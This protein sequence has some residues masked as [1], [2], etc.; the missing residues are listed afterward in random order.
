[1]TVG[2][3]NARL[4]LGEHVGRVVGEQFGLGVDDQFGEQGGGAFDQGVDPLR[5][6]LV[7]VELIDPAVPPD[8]LVGRRE[9]CS[10]ETLGGGQ[11]DLRPVRPGAT[12][13]SHCVG[14]ERRHDRDS[15]DAGPQ[16]PLRP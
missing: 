2:V 13:S 1:M 12:G 4:S 8:L 5:T 10:D 15:T 3:M 16:I 11:T 6:E 14:S 9:G 7:E